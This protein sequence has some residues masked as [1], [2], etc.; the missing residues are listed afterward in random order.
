MIERSREFAR[1]GDLESLIS[2]L[3][4]LLAPAEGSVAARFSAPAYPVILIVGSPRSGT[5]LLL[6]WLASLGEFS[7]PSNLMSR[8]YAAPYV[9]A[10]IQQLLTDERYRFRDEFAELATAQ[11]DF[12]SSLGKTHGILGPNEFWYF[13]RR[14]FR[15]GDLDYL[16]E[17]ALAQADAVAFAAELAAIESAFGKPFAMKAM[18]V[19]SNLRYIAR[20][21][22][23]AIFVYVRRHPFYNIQ[24]LLEARSRFFGGIEHWY[25][26]RPREYPLLRDATPYQQVSGQIYHLN[27]AIESALAA[28]PRE[29]SVSVNY[30]E[31]CA[32]PQLT[33][34]RLRARCAAA[35]YELASEY[36]G[37]ERF[38]RQDT[39]RMSAGEVAASIE[40]YAQFSG[41]EIRP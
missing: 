34:D 30:E 32:R 37:P 11:V 9:G 1:N 6:Q 18:I 2:E 20:I 3:N 7:Y 26:F 17:T 35:G 22:E 10:R 27:Q 25:S 8:F 23:R 29:R 19:N 38:E 31:F 13:W 21:L 4:D 41:Q 39:V 16:D 12:R 24:S 15:F 28:L 5:T 14:F 36:R 33:Y 40:A